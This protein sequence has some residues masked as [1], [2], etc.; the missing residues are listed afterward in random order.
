MIDLTEETEAEL[1]EL[2][3]SSSS[4]ESDV[5]LEEYYSDPETREIMK[6]RKRECMLFA[7]YRILDEGVQP[8]KSWGKTYLYSCEVTVTG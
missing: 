1:C 3:S 8:Q 6:R 2:S 5:S 4:D 7:R